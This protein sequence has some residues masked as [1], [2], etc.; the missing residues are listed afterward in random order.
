[1]STS[2]KDGL[3]TPGGEQPPEEA[4]GR[5]HRWSRRRVL[6][7]TL[8]GLV[9]AAAGGGWAA[10]KWLG[11]RER[12]VEDEEEGPVDGYEAEAGLARG[13]PAEGRMGDEAFAVLITQQATWPCFAGSPKASLRLAKAIELAPTYAPARVLSACWYMHTDRLDLVPEVLSHPSVRDTPEARLLLELAE[14]RPRAPDWRHAFFD[15][16]QALGR[17]DFSKS[18]LLPEPLEWNHVISDGFTRSPSDE[19]WRLP[20]M[21]LYSVL[22]EEEQQWLLEQVRASQSEPLLMALREQLLSLEEQAP[23]RLFLLSAVEERLGQ[24]AGPSP[25]T[26]QLA[27]LSFLAGSSPEAPFERRDLEALEKLVALPEWKQPSS[28]QFF[29]EMLGRIDMMYAPGHHAWGMASLAQGVSLGS[30]LLR[31]ARASRARLIEDEQ[32]WMGRLLWEVGACLREQRSRLELEMGLR[33]QMFG[34]ELT[35]HSAT[36]EESI[37]LWVELGKWEEALKQAAFYRWPLAPLQ[38][39]SCEPR[40]RNEHVWM[41]AFAGKGKLP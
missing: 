41:Q 6:R 2:T 20:L 36:R 25:R 35:G 4:G 10:F 29:R 33:L 26:L 9:P 17:P 39:E 27:L 1:M 3:A 13:A 22:A 11:E 21:V 24:L 16:W 14:R 19:T 38:E 40:A 8:L 5:T 12:R 28:E 23:L 31:R 32:R 7:W 37:D 18:T 30:W 34:S 15:A